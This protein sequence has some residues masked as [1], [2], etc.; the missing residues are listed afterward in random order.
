MSMVINGVTVEEIIR[1]FGEDFDL[2]GGPR[3]AKGF[4]CDW[5]DRYRVVIGLV[6][7]SNPVNVGGVI[8]INA[9]LQYPEI[10][11]IYCHSVRIEPKGPPIRGP[12]QL[13]FSHCIVWAEYRAMPWSWAGVDYQQIDPATPLLYAKQNLSMTIQFYEIPGRALYYKTGKVPTGQSRS[14]PC[15]IINMRITLIRVPYFPAQG[16]IQ[17]ATQGPLNQGIFLGCPDGTVMFNGLENDQT[18]DSEGNFNQ[19]LTYSFSYRPVAPW[20]YGFNPT[21]RIWDQVVDSGNNPIMKRTDL[22]V[23]FPGYY[24]A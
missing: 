23:L 1:D 24:D 7:L 22:R 16:A 10:S 18:W 21:S 11:T 17:A 5:A 8:T 14:F 9:P 13:A 6:G 15:P 19:D 2:Q 20:D 12:A 4:L 3:A